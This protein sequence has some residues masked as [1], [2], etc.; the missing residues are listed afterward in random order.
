MLSDHLPLPEEAAWQQ[1]TSIQMQKDRLH[2]CECVC[3]CV[4][5]CVRGGGGRGKGEGEV[6]GSMGSNKMI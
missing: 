4:C 1:E 6:G 3:V 2:K 5:V